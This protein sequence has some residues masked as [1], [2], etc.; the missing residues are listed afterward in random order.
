MSNIPIHLTPERFPRER[1]I[2]KEREKIDLEKIRYE[3]DIEP[4]SMF[5]H[6]EN[7]NGMPLQVYFSY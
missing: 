4:L 6:A 2:K 5:W 7:L 3:Y 1:P